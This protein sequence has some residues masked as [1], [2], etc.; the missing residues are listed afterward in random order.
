MGVN[1][2]PVV[3]FHQTIKEVEVIAT[4]YEQPGCLY[5]MSQIH[6]LSMEYFTLPDESTPMTLATVVTA[7]I[8]SPGSS[9]WRTLRCLSSGSSSAQWSYQDERG[10]MV[11]TTIHTFGLC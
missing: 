10:P 11:V 4:E 1:N 6:N 5:L 7:S 8:T 2:F 9:W 3:V